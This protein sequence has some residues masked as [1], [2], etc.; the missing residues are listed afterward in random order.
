MINIKKNLLKYFPVHYFISHSSYSQ[1]GEDMILRSFYEG[2]KNYKGFFVDVGAHHPLRFSNTYYFYKKGWKGINIEPTPTA[3]RSFNLLR[4]RDINLSMGVASKR[5]ELTFYCFNE[6][7][8]NSFSKD[9]SLKI[10]ASGRY[11]IIK[12]VKIPVVPLREILDKHLPNGVKI[13][14][15][16]IDVEGLDIEVLLSNDWE[17][18]QP[19]YILVEDRIELETLSESN[20][21]NCLKGKGYKLIAKTLR[22]LFFK[23][24]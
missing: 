22:T 10:H 12:E 16:S 5:D 20:I 14:F 15:L 17:K 1:E 18:Y 4:K 11:K 7:A 6:P 23:H 9:L 2:K 19:E 21:Y 13:D 24:I 8:L 3:I